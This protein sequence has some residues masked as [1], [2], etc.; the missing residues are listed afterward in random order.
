MPKNALLLCLL[1][2]C[3]TLLQE[4]ACFSLFSKKK[5]SPETPPRVLLVG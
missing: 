5:A 1:V 4:G 3:A 2:L